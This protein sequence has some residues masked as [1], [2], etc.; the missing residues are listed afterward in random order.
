MGIT[1]IGACAKG[2]CN[3]EHTLH[4]ERGV[5]S[6][7]TSALDRVEQPNLNSRYTEDL[8]FCLQLWGKNKTL[9]FVPTPWTCIQYRSLPWHQQQVVKKQRIRST[10]A[11]STLLPEE[12]K[13][14][15]NAVMLKGPLPWYWELHTAND[16]AE[17]QQLPLPA[18]SLQPD[19]SAI[20]AQW[21][22]T[23]LFSQCLTFPGEISIDMCKIVKLILFLSDQ[24]SSSSLKGHLKF[25]H[26]SDWKV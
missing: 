10:N 5:F 9:G 12:V 26:W 13:A 8:N 24:T 15:Q 2:M 3:T 21:R 11:R 1:Q 18:N 22:V 19:M 25:G 6:L 23:Q 16:G 4:T 7:G 14:F 20:P 17:H